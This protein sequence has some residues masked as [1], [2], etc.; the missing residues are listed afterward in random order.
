M[1]GRLIAV[2][3]AMAVSVLHAAGAQAAP[4]ASMLPT[5]AGPMPVGTTTMHLVQH[6]RPDPFTPNTDRELMMSVFYPAGDVTNSPRAHALSAIVVPVLERQLGVSLPVLLSNSYQEAPVAAGSYPVVLYSPGQSTPRLL[7]TGTAEEL[8]SHG[9]VV[10]TIDHTGDSPAIEFPD[11]RIVGAAPEF[12]AIP[13]GQRRDIQVADVEFVL[14]TLTA[15]HAGINPDA[16]NR[17]L[18]TGL[19]AALDLTHIGGFGHSLGGT[20]AVEV[21]S[22]DQRISA[23]LDM[24]GAIPDSDDWG[25]S[26]TDGVSQPLLVLRSAQTV[27]S[28][29]G[30]EAFAAMLDHAQGWKLELEL[31][32]SAHEDLTDLNQII[33]SPMYLGGG[34]MVGPI[35]P[36]RANT[37]LRT[38]VTAFFDKFLRANRSTALEHPNSIPDITVM[39]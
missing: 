32:N 1:V 10:V 13:G 7:G 6:G 28:G 4:S 24:D 27:D 30:R 37:A 16:E 22:Q 35:P 5:P 25:K 33:P 36:A 21:A 12:T 11:G 23:V 38:A 34:A 15:L 39:R 14:D 31:E 8:A 2:S 26:G 20:T 19:G 29:A 3:A 18:P 9:Y 17:A